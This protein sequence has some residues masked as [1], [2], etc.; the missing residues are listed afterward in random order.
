MENDMSNNIKYK[1]FF[2]KYKIALQ[3]LHNITKLTGKLTRKH[4]LDRRKVGK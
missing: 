4:D 3:F 1:K 2:L